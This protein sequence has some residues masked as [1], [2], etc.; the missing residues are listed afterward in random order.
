MFPPFGLWDYSD[1][2]L[3]ANLW[4][5]SVFCHVYALVA[6]FRNVTL[7]REVWCINEAAGE[8]DKTLQKT[9]FCV[10][11]KVLWDLTSDLVPGPR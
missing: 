5:S 11:G 3:F 2:L 6:K 10:K 1:F 7:G 8:K 9:K 4:V